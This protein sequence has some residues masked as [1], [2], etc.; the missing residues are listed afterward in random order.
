MRL[1]WYQIRRRDSSHSYVP[2]RDS[3]FRDAETGGLRAESP[4]LRLGPFPMHA[5]VLYICPEVWIR[6][7]EPD[8]VPAS[9]AME[10]AALSP[11]EVE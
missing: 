8:P 10:Q 11:G 7:G 2:P 3:P 5:V 6:S 4:G 1:P 9:A